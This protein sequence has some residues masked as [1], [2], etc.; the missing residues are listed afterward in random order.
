[1]Q[2][3][4][5]LKYIQVSNWKK[6]KSKRRKYGLY[7]DAIAINPEGF[8]QGIKHEEHFAL[9]ALLTEWPDG[10][11]PKPENG[12][13]W[14][15]MALS[16]FSK[17]KALFFTVVPVLPDKGIPPFPAVLLGHTGEIVHTHK[18]KSKSASLP[19]SK[20]GNRI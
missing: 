20:K 8:A 2:P 19:L 5:P 13:V 9:H 11:L 4:K 18:N 10:K 14:K 12:Q 15:M 6:A 3:M 16:Q 7:V 17:F 1:M